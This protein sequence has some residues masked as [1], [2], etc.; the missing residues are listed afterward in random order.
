MKIFQK[1]ST[2]NNVQN[3]GVNNNSGNN[4]ANNSTSGAAGGSVSV[5]KSN[6]NDSPY[7]Y[8]LLQETS[9]EELESW[10]Y[11]IRYQGNEE[12]LA[13]L[14]KQLDEVQWIL[15]D[16]LSTFDL[17][18]QYLVSER[19]AKEMTKVDLNSCGFHRK[20]DGKLEKINLKFKPH[21]SNEKKMVKA[22][23]VLGY[24]KIENYVSD[25]DIDPEDLQNEDSDSDEEDSE[26]DSS[27]GSDNKEDSRR[28]SNAGEKNKNSSSSSE[29]DKHKKKKGALPG[30]VGNKIPLP[31]FAK[32]KAKRK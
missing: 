30:V 25:E 18:T 12:A 1:M 4:S 23:G 19:T 22:F 7:T 13:Y 24:G 31:G 14:E 5:T 21:Y 17:E 10:Y 3:M 26:S 2:E 9:G 27:S 15:E 20:F 29:V 11:F 16:D 28:P 6:L 32:A 8:A